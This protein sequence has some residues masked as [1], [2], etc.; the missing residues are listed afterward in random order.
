MSGGTVYSPFPGWLGQWVETAN[1]M[2]QVLNLGMQQISGGPP[3]LNW[4][5]PPPRPKVKPTRVVCA[6]CGGPDYEERSCPGCG[7][8]EKEARCSG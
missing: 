5:P 3:T 2:R 8:T 6:Y 4:N 7:A 1:E